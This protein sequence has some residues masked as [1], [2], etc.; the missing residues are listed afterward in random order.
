MISDSKNQNLPKIK[1]DCY[2]D[3]VWDFDLD[4][5]I[6]AFYVL[7]KKNRNSQRKGMEQMTA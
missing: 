2:D 4:K 7:V 6:S 5:V 3:W 1:N